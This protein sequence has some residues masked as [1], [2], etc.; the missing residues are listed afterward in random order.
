MKKSQSD[1]EDRRRKSL[2]PWGRKNSGQSRSKSRDRG[3]E[4]KVQ[5]DSSSVRSE[6]TGSRSSLASS[7]LALIQRNSNSRQ[8]KLFNF[9]HTSLRQ[10]ILN[11]SPFHWEM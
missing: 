6:L 5:D 3:A 9:G 8:V 7:D 4:E 1:A 2:L 10:M 11:Y